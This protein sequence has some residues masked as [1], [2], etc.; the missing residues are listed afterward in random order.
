[1]SSEESKQDSEGTQNYTVLGCL[2]GL[3]GRAHDSWSWGC[4]C[5]PHDGP[6]AYLKQNYVV[7]KE[8]G[9]WRK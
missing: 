7:S 4:K 9:V 2:A 8:S 1:M 3:V 6:S 5:K